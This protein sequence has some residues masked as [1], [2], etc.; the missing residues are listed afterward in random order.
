MHFFRAKTSVLHCRAG[1]VPGAGGWIFCKGSR[2]SQPLQSSSS[3]SLSSLQERLQGL[4]AD[5]SS[6]LVFMKIYHT[7]SSQCSLAILWHV[8]I[9]VKPSPLGWYFGTQVQ[10]PSSSNSYEAVPTIHTT[11]AP[12]IWVRTPKKV[13]LD[14]EQPLVSNFRSKL[15]TSHHRVSALPPFSLG[16]SVCALNAKTTS[17]KERPGDLEMSSS[18]LGHSSSP[19]G[20]HPPTAYWAPSVT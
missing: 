20:L 1:S 11:G 19:S 4:S 7:F 9:V 8:C 16:Q 10:K 3:G 15:S 5:T 6:L 2:F 12:H 18:P 13:D 17:G 14:E